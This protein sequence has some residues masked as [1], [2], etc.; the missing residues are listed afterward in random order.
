MI[1]AVMTTA[2]AGTVKA[3]TTYK[4]QQVTSVEAG[5]MYVFEQGGYVMNNNCSSS[6]LQTTNIY[7]TTGLVGTET[8][9][10][11]LES[12][13]NG[14]Y[15]KNVNLS[16]LPYLNNTSSTN[17]S[18]GTKNTIWKFTFQGDNTVLIQRTADSRF[19]GYTNSTSHAYKAYAESNLS[20]YSHA[21]K[22]YQ[23]VEDSSSPV[24][25]TTTTII[26]TGITNTDVYTGTTAG[27][28]SATVTANGTAVS[29]ATVTW[30]GDNDNV[31]TI[32][33]NTG[34]V[35]LVGAGSVKFTASY[36]GQS[37]VYLSSSAEYTM[38][39]T[40]SDPTK[41]TFDATK[42]KDTNNTSQGEGSITKSGVTFSCTSGILGNG[43]EYR[44]YKNSTTTFSASVGTITKIVFVGTSSNPASGFTSQTG[45]TTNGND[46]TWTGNASS[47]SFVA[48][49]A[50]VRATA[51]LVTLDMSATSITA[52][53]V[54]IDYGATSGSITYTINNPV[55]GGVLTATTNDSWLTLGTVGET[56]PFTCSANNTYT[57]RTASVTLTYTYNTSETVT[58]T[59]TVT[60]AA[61][62][63]AVDNISDITEVG[64][65]YRV[66]GTVVATNARGFIIGDGTDYVYTYLNAAP[67]QAIGD[68]VT[69]SGTTGSYG[70]I[71]QFTNSATVAEATTSDYDN[72][73]AVSV[74]TGVPDYS[75]GYHLST[76]L[77]FE[78]TLSV[79]NNVNL[80]NVGGTDIQISYPTTAQ[81]T[82]LAALNGK[83]VSVKGYFS[84]IN[85]SDR[86][87]VM[88]ESV[89]EVTTPVLSVT[90]AETNVGFEAT[91]GTLDVTATNFSL[92]DVESSSIQ[93]FVYNGSDYAAGSQP[94]WLTVEY[95]NAN[96]VINYTVA[97]N[98]GA[99]RSA[100][101]KLVL[102]YDDDYIYSD[103]ITINQAAYVAPSTEGTIVFGNNGTNITAASVTGDDSMGNTWTIT[104][105]GTTS[106]TQSTD[107][108]QVG[109]SSK[110]A[111]SI[112]FTTTLPAEATITSFEAK[113]GGFK[114]TAGDVTLKVGENTV[115]SGSLNGTADVIVSNTSTAT[116][117]TLTVTVTNIAK[118][119][120]CYY[121]S[122][123]VEVEESIKVKLNASGYATFASTQVLD[124]TDT[125]GYTAWAVTA[126]NGS[127]ITF[128]QIT[129]PVP[130]GTGVLLKGTAST[131][132]TLATGTEGTAPAGNLLEGV[133]A[134]KAIEAGQYYGLSGTKFVKVKK[135]IIPAGKALLPASV[136]EGEGTPVNAFTFNFDEDATAIKA[137]D[138]GQLTTDGVIY[139]VAG[140]RLSKMQ[141]GINIVNGKK[142]LK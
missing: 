57:E 70:H 14:Y 5:G 48:S 116:G 141:K 118:G 89:E 96:A 51:I 12:A 93:Y 49:G 8:Y 99:A 42:D 128:S 80:I 15:M 111:T 10:W 17:V 53:D 77:K 123:E 134:P 112:T 47:V 107:Y 136:V 63:N 64:V 39:V 6:A 102:G 16:N 84:G 130:A 3:E 31:A 138:N 75:E 25:A 95:D 82:A 120:K 34:V 137:I 7:N 110:P 135:G 86:F 60:Q 13:T 115:G 37:G 104:S 139:N 32:N 43:T 44:M 66:R 140:Q 105:E 98:A 35:T 91:S 27:S 81:S 30:S 88:L 69:V 92:D 21:I 46:G 101:F 18:F 83:T 109:S 11:T 33:A 28:L 9:V 26:T 20:S 50:Q 103:I 133:V 1:V 40:D 62:P 142:I 61:N 100:Y 132:Y 2:L 121:I 79:S 119:V 72:T 22:V 117:T 129:G 29:G 56:I 19:L 71:I 68:K 78:G 131:E 122:Y 73:P 41:V 97:A 65:S 38:T 126:V 52:D 106:F 85:S 23:L 114:D 45:W 124:F 87:T 36:A 67:T 94:D 74:I 4:L 76:Y 54:D 24:V 113:L 59:I 55:A 108:S 127:T 90:P 125:E 58:E